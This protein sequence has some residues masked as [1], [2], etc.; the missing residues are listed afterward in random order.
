MAVT[1]AAQPTLISERKNMPRL[2]SSSGQNATFSRSFALPGHRFIHCGN[3]QVNGLVNGQGRGK[4]EFAFVVSKANG[5]TVRYRRLNLNQLQGGDY[6]VDAVLEPDYSL[7]WLSNHLVPNVVPTLPGTEMYALTQTDTLGNVR[8]QRLYPKT[9]VLSVTALLRVPDG[10]LAI[11]NAMSVAASTPTATFPQAGVVK[12]DRQGLLRW[13]RTWPSRGYGGVGEL[14]GLVARPDGSYLATG[15]TD[16][17]TFYAGGAALPRYDHWLVQFTPQGDTIRTARFGTNGQFETGFRVY[18]T[19]DGGA[20][21]SGARRLNVAY[22]VNDAQLVKVDSLFRPQWTYTQPNISTYAESFG[23][24]QP[25]TRGDILYGGGRWDYYNQRGWSEFNAHS[26]GSAP[27]WTWRYNFGG[28]ALRPTSIVSVVFRPDSSAYAAGATSANASSTVYEDFFARF[29]NVGAPFVANLCRVPPQ[30][31]FGY[32]PTAGG[33]SLR[34]V[35]LSAPG[36]QYA[37]LALWHW[38][39][40]DGTSYDGPTPPP[41]RYPPGTSAGTAVR[42]TVTNNLGCTS[43]QTV[44]PLVLATAAPAFAAQASLWPNP[45]AGAATLLVAGL[46]PQGPVALQVVNALGQVVLARSVRVQQGTVREVLALDGLPPGVYAV[47][48]R[49]V[50][51]VIIK[52]MVIK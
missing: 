48:L 43:T 40:G 19:R 36:P 39:F 8:W 38:D 24:V 30:A 51:G 22:A 2:R 25:T 52:R 27:R 4:Q 16:N 3:A 12:F 44:Y 46:R 20:A 10:Y 15:Y 45:T 31:L 17:G 14:G 35:S 5:D 29:A 11:V 1:V 23:F 32:A 34:F 37:T 28:N 26:G 49:A 13:Q 41:H 18:N 33:D 7:T 47:R 6:F 42:L 21:I 50:E 9:N